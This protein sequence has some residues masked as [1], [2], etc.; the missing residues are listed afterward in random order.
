MFTLILRLY[1]PLCTI[2]M[3]FIMINVN[4][5]VA[6]DEKQKIMEEVIQAVCAATNKPRGFIQVGIQECFMSFGGSTEPSANVV[7]Y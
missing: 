4:V 3:P 1:T 7:C 2:K 6:D 5:S